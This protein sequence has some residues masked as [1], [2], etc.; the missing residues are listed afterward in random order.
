MES[1]LRLAIPAIIFQ[2]HLKG[3]VLDGDSLPS[4]LSLPNLSALVKNKDLPVSLKD[5]LIDYLRD[6]P[7]YDFMEEEQS[8]DVIDNHGF[9]QMQVTYILPQ[10]SNSL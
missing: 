4:L 8:Q 3:K 7:G 6:V 9:V 1:L 10:L 5:D 2:C